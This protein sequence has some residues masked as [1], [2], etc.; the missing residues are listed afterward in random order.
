MMAAMETAAMPAQNRTYELVHRLLLIG[1]DQFHINPTIMPS[2]PAAN[3]P[4]SRSD[5]G[6]FVPIHWPARLPSIA[7][8]TAGIVE[9]IPSG[10]QVLLLTQVWLPNPNR[11]QSSRS[12]SHH[13]AI[14][15]DGV[16]S[17]IAPRTPLS[18]TGKIV[19]ANQ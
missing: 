1:N 13:A 12:R 15:C 18:G 19:I 4:F 2:A 14:V 6:R 9:R 3:S 7:V 8:P 17:M 10:S 11:D 16:S 5:S